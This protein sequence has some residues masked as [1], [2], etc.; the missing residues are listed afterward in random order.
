[1]RQYTLVFMEQR[2][3]MARL[4]PING[5]AGSATFPALDEES[6]IFY[7]Q[8]HLIDRLKNCVR[9][10]LSSMRIVRD[11][12][13]SN[14]IRLVDD[15][16]ANP[17]YQDIYVRYNPVSKAVDVDWDSTRTTLFVD[18]ATSSERNSRTGTG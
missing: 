15:S 11:P 6:A 14:G 7:I 13:A 3:G 17:N 2:I 12:T 5:E 16:H 18:L 9:G 4:T 10:D 1:M 8:Q